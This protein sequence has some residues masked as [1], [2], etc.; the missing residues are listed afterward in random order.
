MQSRKRSRV[1]NGDQNSMQNDVPVKIE[2]AINYLLPT[3]AIRYFAPR[4]AQ[5]LLANVITK[6]AMQSLL[7]KENVTE[8][9]RSTKQTKPIEKVERKR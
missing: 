2:P 1:K 6:N 4:T 3:E 8:K 5:I 7:S 9:G